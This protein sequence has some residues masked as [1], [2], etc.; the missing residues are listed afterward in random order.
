MNRSR[1]AT[2]HILKL[3]AF[4]IIVSL[5]C[6]GLAFVLKHITESV[7][8]IIYTKINTLN[9]IYFILLPTI[10]ITT[11]YFL[12]K[13]LFKNRKNKGITEIY[14]TIDD[15]K[16]HL[17]LFKI[18]SHF[19][20][21]FLTVITGGSTG[22]EVSTVVASATVGN[23][24]YK[25]EF[26]AK[27]YKTE[28]ICAGVTA[29]VAVLFCSPLAGW[30]F[31]IEVIARNIRKTILL[32]SSIAALTVWLFISLFD[33]HHLLP[34]QVSNWQWS[35]LPFFVILSLLGGT[36]SVYL[37]KLVIILKGSFNRI[38]NNFLRVNIGAVT[39]G[40]LICLLPFLYGDSYHG[41]THVMEEA[42]ANK[43]VSIGILLMLIFLKPVAS[44]LT[45]AAGGDGGVFA[46][47]IV[48]GA[49]LG[50]A[51]ALVCNQY[52][53]THLI[54]LNFALV[55]AAA[56]LSASIYAPLTAMVL[57]C[58]LVPNGYSLLLP[59]VTG[60]F[61]ASFF[62]SKLLP[63]NVYTYD[64]YMAKKENENLGLA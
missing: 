32:S 7:E 62:A 31:A 13:Y 29:G 4:S 37:T 45:L 61:I 28:L 24:F 16:E 54:P 53:G 36:I 63:Y 60:S 48:T 46:P 2:Y 41:L 52:L 42:I 22:I 9:K 23:A 64:A 39:V 59:I 1:I 55:G 47:S 49:V 58:N 44:A 11:I 21:G 56:M 40:I 18:P 35:A 20:N 17:P 27:K 25:N 8:S 10:G 5:F 15:R 50:L 34:F 14:K 33:N 26:S 51:F 43:E 30:L 19:F 12:R 6:A 3:V 38:N 57:V